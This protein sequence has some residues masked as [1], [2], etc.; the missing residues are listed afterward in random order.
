M[1]LSP[2]RTP[3]SQSNDSAVRRKGS[4]TSH[5]PWPTAHQQLRRRG[6]GS[7]GPKR[8]PSASA[9]RTS[10]SSTFHRQARKA[11]CPPCREPTR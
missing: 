9:W 6:R 8:V 7:A 3:F 2:P 11:F 10:V 4:A 5:Q 1:S